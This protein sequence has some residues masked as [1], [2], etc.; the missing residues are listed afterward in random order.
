MKKEATEWVEKAEEDYD[1]AQSM[2][3]LARSKLCTNLFPCT[4]MYRK[5]LKSTLN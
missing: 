3:E 2:M 1:A 4:A 5:I